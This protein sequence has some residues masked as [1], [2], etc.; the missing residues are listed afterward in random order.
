MNILDLPV[1]LLEMIFVNCVHSCSLRR[2]SIYAAPSTSAVDLTHVCQLWRTIAISTPQ[3]W[4][5]IRLN[6]A[7]SEGDVKMFELWLQRSA[8]PT[9]NYP[10]ALAI[11]QNWEFK[12][13]FF[14][15]MV[16]LAIAEHK[17]WRD[18]HLS[19]LGISQAFFEPLFTATPLPILQGF[20]LYF[21]DWNPE[22][23]GLL[24]R[25]LC[26]SPALQSV[27]F[28]WNLL[29]SQ[30]DLLKEAAPWDRQK[31][32]RFDAIDPSQFVLILSFSA[33]SLQ[34]IVASGVTP[35]S[36]TVSTPIPHV[37]AVTLQSIEIKRFNR[38]HCSNVFDKL[39]LP[40]LQQLHLPGGLKD[41]DSDN[42]IAV[43]SLF[44]LL[45]RSKC[46]LQALTIGSPTTTFLE[47]PFFNDLKTLKITEWPTMEAE[48]QSVEA[49]GEACSGTQCPRMFPFLEVLTLQRVESVDRVR[50][51]AYARIAASGG[52]G[53]SKL[54]RVIAQRVQNGRYIL[55]MDFSAA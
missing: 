50:E 32:A 48:A 19:L 55:D 49:L 43:E 2:K 31:N 17:R 14:G 26:S 24:M 37:T 51:I 1:E 6:N 7:S 16:S 12:M 11:T 13:E 54:R 33:S 22:E 45:E 9:G 25:T 46:K 10:L 34:T 44:K 4:A 20:Q 36:F 21:Y 53:R 5:R 27:H 52:Q 42:H 8:G 35:K 41:S 30:S 15:P 18:I 28:G 3:L 47:S 29:P 39:T 38:C 23:R 40:S